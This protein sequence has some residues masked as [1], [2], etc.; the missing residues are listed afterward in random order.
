M[1][2]QPCM[3]ISELIRLQVINMSSFVR[4]TKVGMDKRHKPFVDFLSVFTLIIIR[5]E[6][7]FECFQETE[8]SNCFWHKYEMQRLKQASISKRLRKLKIFSF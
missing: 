3:Q 7:Y 8:E 5:W 4:C 2:I 6:I 1:Q